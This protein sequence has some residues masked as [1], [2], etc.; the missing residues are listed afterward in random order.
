MRVVGG[1]FRGRNLAAPKSQAIRP[2]QDR[3]RESLFNILM[4]AYGNPIADARVLDVP[5]WFLLEVTLTDF[6]I[7]L[8]A[9]PS[10]DRMVLPIDE[11]PDQRHPSEQPK[12]RG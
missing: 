6:R 3:L 10:R 8:F 4:H 5:E 11:P 7:A 12:L 1:R 2:T 9:E